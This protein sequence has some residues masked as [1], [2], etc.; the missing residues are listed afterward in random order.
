M[1]LSRSQLNAITNAELE[2]RVITIACANGDRQ[3]D[4]PRMLAPFITND[5][6]HRLHEVSARIL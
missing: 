2:E 1:Y 6:L 3:T 5:V 4:S